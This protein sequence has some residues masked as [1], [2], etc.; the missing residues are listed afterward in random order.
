MQ[1]HWIDN[2][3]DLL[4]WC[5]DLDG[6]PLAVD[7]ESDHFHAYQAR[8]CL[9][10]LATDDSSA[11]V[12][13]LALEA[14]ELAPLFELF[15]DPDRTKVLHAGRNDINELDRDYGVG[16]VNLF[17]TRTAARFLNYDNNGLTWLL[18]DVLDVEDAGG[19]GRYDWSTRPLSDKA[20]HYASQDVRHLLALRERFADEL[21]AVG[22]DEPFR[23]RCRHVARSVSFEANEF[24][25]A[26]WRD[27]RGIDGLDG[28]GRAA[29][30]ALY[31]WRH[32]LCTRLNR[33]AVTTFPNKALLE[34]AARRPDSPEAL[35]ELSKLPERIATEHAD[36]LLEV[37]DQ[38]RRAD[39]PPADAPDDGG[40]P[41][42]PPSG[43]RARYDALRNWRNETADQLGIPGEFL[44]TN[45][46][47]S[48][49][50][51]DPPESLDELAAFDPILDWHV[52]MFGDEIL[53]VLSDASGY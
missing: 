30:R 53:G 32:R 38:A 2:P 4:G 1:P 43:H 45:D 28:R 29:A 14:D 18:E 41:G 12:D 37:L 7:T 16:I 34:L 15:E 19:M 9:I 46:T 33:S 47:F 13:P 36:E 50:A 39:A 48:E 22:W 40:D 35:A 11:L 23:Q 25:P 17:D 10:Q 51:A 49:I 27:L 42:P 44:A 21:Q 8:L 24:D 31:R 5:D 20:R 52:E 6:G 3:D 26:G